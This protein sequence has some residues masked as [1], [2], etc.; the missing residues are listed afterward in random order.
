[1]SCGS[2]IEWYDNIPVFSWLALRGRCRTCGSAISIQYPL[3]EASTGALFALIGASIPTPIDVAHVVEQLLPA[4]VIASLLIAIAAYDIRHTIIP[5]A[6][7]YSFACAAIVWG[8]FALE[9]QYGLPVF[10]LSGPIAALPLFSLWAMSRGRWMGLGDVK[11]AL[12]IGWLLGPF[13]GLFAIFFSF[14]LGA[15]VSVPL[16]LLS[17][18]LWKQRMSWFTHTASSSKRATGFT[19]ASE[20]PFGPFLIASCIIVW[21]FLINGVELTQTFGL[22]P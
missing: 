17:S 12:G 14:I 9:P 18:E 20:I 6:W 3:V 15:G 4:C 10:I 22:L 16:L 8:F 21:L 19:M 5:D 11:L 2:R 13:N 1:M 7:A